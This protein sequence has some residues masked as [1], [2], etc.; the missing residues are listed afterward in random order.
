MGT[1]YDF[2][3]EWPEI[4]K[5]LVKLSNEALDFAKKGEKEIV[6]ISKQ[7]KLHVDATALTLKKEQL[8]HRI[9]KE[10][11]KAKCPDAPTSKLKKLINDIHEVD[12]KTAALKKQM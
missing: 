6:R 4:K 2:K 12:R 1:Q 11:I 9:G 8:Y 5:Q 3:K 7:G 10:Y